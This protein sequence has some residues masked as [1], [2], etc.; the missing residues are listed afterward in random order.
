MSLT[1]AESLLINDFNM[2]FSYDINI[3]TNKVNKEIKFDD[4]DEGEDM[5]EY[6]T[7]LE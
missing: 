2:G 7:K 3:K 5:E 4:E 1:K 6:F